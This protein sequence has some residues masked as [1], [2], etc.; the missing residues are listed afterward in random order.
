MDT[1]IIRKYVFNKKK[2]KKPF[3]HI[4]FILFFAFIYLFI[5]SPWCLYVT[6]PFIIIF[7]KKISHLM[8]FFILRCPWILFH[9]RKCPLDVF[10]WIKIANYFWV[11]KCPLENFHIFTLYFMKQNY[12]SN[13]FI[14]GEGNKHMLSLYILCC[15]YNKKDGDFSYYERWQ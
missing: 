7:L 6:L 1:D 4:L 2:K 15:F 13:I 5:Y 11:K 9:I 3:M 12:T 14:T 8:L 10:I